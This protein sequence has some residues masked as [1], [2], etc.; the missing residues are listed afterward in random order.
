M[1]KKE[2]GEVVVEERSAPDG[3]REHHHNQHHLTQGGT[4]SSMSTEKRRPHPLPLRS[5]DGCVS[6]LAPDWSAALPSSRSTHTL[7]DS[8]PGKQVR[9]ESL[10]SFHVATGAF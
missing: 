7:S 9:L 4:G 10:T 6:I 8:E 5:D 1:V 3:L 2:R